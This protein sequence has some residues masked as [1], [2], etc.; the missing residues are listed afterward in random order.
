MQEAEWSRA[1]FNTVL[2]KDGSHAPHM[3]TF[4]SVAVSEAI[5]GYDWTQMLPVPAGCFYLLKTNKKSKLTG[6][7]LAAS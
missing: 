3:Q 1:T 4:L 6:F 7:G 2:N 5:L